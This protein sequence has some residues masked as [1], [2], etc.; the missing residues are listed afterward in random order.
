MKL[1]FICA[2][3]YVVATSTNITPSLASSFCLTP[4]QYGLF[5][6]LVSGKCDVKS[7]V[8]QF[9]STCKECMYLD[10]QSRKYIGIDFNL[11]QHDAR[12]IVTYFGADYDKIV[13]GPAT[14]MGTPCDCKEVECLNLT[15]INNIFDESIENA[16]QNARQVLPIFDR[17]GDQY[18]VIVLS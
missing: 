2:C 8:R 14:A 7:Y 10:T 13:N 12:A 16:A 1:Y 17:Y 11:E 3:V 6:A 15:Q 4:S 18:T 9:E 5:Q